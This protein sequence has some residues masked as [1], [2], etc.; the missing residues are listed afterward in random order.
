MLDKLAEAILKLI[1]DT[2]ITLPPDVEEA[3][4]SAWERESSAIARLQL[5]MVLKNI[6]L[7]KELRRPICQDTGLLTFFISA[8]KRYFSRNVEKAI[9]IAIKRAVK[10]GILR[11]NIV[12]P[13]TRLPCGNCTKASLINYW[14]PGEGLEISLLVKGAGSEN[15]SVVKVLS[16]GVGVE[17]VKKTVV[18][19]VLSAGGRPCPPVFIGIG[20]GGTVD[21]AARLAKKALLRKVGE[22]NPNLML[23]RLEEEILKEVNALGIGPMGLGGAVTAL[24]V[25]IESANCHTASLP[26]AIIFQCWAH[27]RGRVTLA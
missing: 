24:G 17:G 4:K 18:D 6:E 27:R 26:I 23:A 16:P 21:F 8:E 9:R 19:A 5:E 14:E 22:P 2:E 13:L 1:E 12:D 15:V 3:I 11:P 20:L 7:A 10:S 25:S